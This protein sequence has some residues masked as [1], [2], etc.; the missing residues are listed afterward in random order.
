MPFQIFENS[1]EAVIQTIT[2]LGNYH[3]ATYVLSMFVAAMLLILAF[4]VILRNMEQIVRIEGQQEELILARDKI[5]TLSVEVMEALSAASDSKDAYT[6]G[7]STRVAKYSRMIAEKL[8][9]SAEECENV[10]YYGLLHD[11]GKIGVPNEIINKPGKLTDEEFAIIKTHPGQGND[12]LAHIKSRPDL[13]IVAHW[14]HERIDGRGYPDKIN[15]DEIP[16]LA[17]IIAVADSY[18]AMTSNRSYRKY[19]P[20]EVV[21]EEIVKNIGIK[22]DER[23][24]KCMLEIMDEDAEYKLHE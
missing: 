8:G 20:Q 24:A 17:R 22:F 13:A 6:A 21:R 18:D 12:I 16:F 10:Y 14:H 11:V 7:H 2:R 19:L 4:N 5:K 23:A 1:D 9:L 3:T 15:G